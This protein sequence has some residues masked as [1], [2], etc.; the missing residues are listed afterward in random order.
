MEKILIIKLGALGAVLRDTSLL[1]PMKNKY[2][3]SIIHFIT[4]E[5]ALELLYNNP[6]I[7]KILTIETLDKNKLDKD[8]SIVFSLDEDSRACE[9]ASLF[10]EKVIGFYKENNKVLPTSSAVEW[11][12]MCALGKEVERDI[13]KKQNKK[14]YQ[15]I[16]LEFTGLWPQKKDDYELILS[17]TEDELK[18][19][20]D[21]KKEL[22]AENKKV[23]GLS[24]GAGGRWYHKKLDVKKTIDLANK[25]L[26]NEDYFIMLFGGPEEEERN[27][28]IYEKINKKGSIIKIQDL[29]IR[30]FASI[31]NQCDLI[32]TSDSLAMHIASALKKK[33]IV[34]FGPTSSNEI[35]LYDR[36]FKIFSDL[37]C[38]CCYKTICSKSPSCIDK[39]DVNDFIE[40]T[41]L[42]LIDQ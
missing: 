21:F 34:F 5:N 19:G 36:G 33:V 42:L 6:Y 39:I 8:Y 37:D 23:I 27:N 26:E 38:L 18:F 11:F 22:N 41:K 29:S 32:I 25:L 20:E 4:Q 10:K 30:K 24:T 15:Q 9:I 1:K 16:M 28:Q 35:E 2:P 31:I 12:D 14:T 3:D 40:K 17:L 13:L 7:D